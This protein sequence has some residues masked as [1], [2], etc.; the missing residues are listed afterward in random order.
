MKIVY[1]VH[2]LP[3]RYT[4]GAE[5]RARRTAR[6]FQ[7]HGHATAAICVEAIDCGEPPCA[8]SVDDGV[9]AL[10]PIRRVGNTT[11]H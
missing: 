2:H 5:N 10:P 7:S 8:D 9:F 1:A 3:P 4:G 6:W 11:T